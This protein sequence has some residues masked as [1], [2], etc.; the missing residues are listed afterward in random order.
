MSAVPVVMVIN[1]PAAA[2]CQSASRKLRR[3]LREGFTTPRLPRDRHPS[4]PPAL[5]AAAAMPA[6]CAAMPVPFLAFLNPSVPQEARARG[7]LAAE[8]TW[9]WVLGERGGTEGKRDLR[10]LRERQH[11]LT[12]PRERASQL[13]FLGTEP[14]T[15]CL[16]SQRGRREGQGSPLRTL[17]T[18]RSCGLGSSVMDRMFVSPTFTLNS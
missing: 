16:N 11:V 18:D 3:V 14:A 8:R 9:I 4:P 6:V 15:C 17:K 7:W 2:H 1:T 5:T 12:R 10:G 13:L